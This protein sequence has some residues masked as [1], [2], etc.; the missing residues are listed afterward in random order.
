MQTRDFIPHIQP[1]ELEALLFSDVSELVSIEPKW[2]SAL[3]S[4]QAVLINLVARN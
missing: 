3:S 1:H 4:L 2:N